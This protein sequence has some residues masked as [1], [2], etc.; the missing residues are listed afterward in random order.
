MV[1]VLM[2]AA[3]C[4][5]YS[6][7][8]GRTSPMARTYILHLEDVRPQYGGYKNDWPACIIS[9][10][11]KSKRCLLLIGKLQPFFLFIIQII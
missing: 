1:L 11:L 10:S 8:R 3:N 6:P 5:L 2:F 9:M 4:I 7:M